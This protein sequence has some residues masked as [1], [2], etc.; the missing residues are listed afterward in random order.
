MTEPAQA[1]PHSA[2][3]IR[4]SILAAQLLASGLIERIAEQLRADYI[5]ARCRHEG[6][7]LTPAAVHARAR[8]LGDVVAEFKKLATE[9]ILNER[10][11]TD[12][13]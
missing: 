12:A 8:V 3:D 2:D 6:D 1:R 10:D 4:A 5:A 7:E 11:R 9:A 13:A